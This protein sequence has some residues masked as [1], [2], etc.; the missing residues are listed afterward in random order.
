MAG[1]I[2]ERSQYFDATLF[3]AHIMVTR[4]LSVFIDL[5]HWVTPNRR[6]GVLLAD[7]F[8]GLSVD[9]TSVSRCELR[10]R[11]KLCSKG[12]IYR[13]LTECLGWDWRIALC[14][15]DPSKV[16]TTTVRVSIL[17]VFTLA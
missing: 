8:A 16:F 3:T 17:R 9:E 6:C 5:S 4:W 15:P 10:G 2:S 14:N 11:F 7:L 12:R 13:N 1:A